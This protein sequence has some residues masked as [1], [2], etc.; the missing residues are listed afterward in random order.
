MEI[1]TLPTQNVA[2]GWAM[3]RDAAEPRRGHGDSSRSF[4]E[5]RESCYRSR[6]TIVLVRAPRFVSAASLSVSAVD[7]LASAYRDHRPWLLGWLR[8]R[9]GCPHRAE[10][11][12]QDTFERVV[13]RQDRYVLDEARALLTVIAKGLVVDHYRRAALEA[14]CLDALARLPEAVAPSPEARAVLLETLVQID[15]LLDG[16]PG[17]VRRAF[18]LSQ[19]DGLT[20]PQIAADLGVSVRTVQQYMTRALTAC[21]VAQVDA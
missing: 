5:V 8:R 13:A 10:D 20:Y 6:T 11:L 9:L 7:R 21:V 15:R 19:L 14:A 4:G 18:L 16:L 17:R 3:K 1:A 2:P 12:A